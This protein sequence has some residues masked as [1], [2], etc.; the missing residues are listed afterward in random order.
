M[1][2]E[3]QRVATE[4]LCKL[5][6]CG[7]YRKNEEAFDEAVDSASARA[8]K[9]WELCGKVRAAVQVENKKE[10]EVQQDH[11]GGMEVERM[12]VAP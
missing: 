7:F 9:G 12:S 6:L 8:A 1:N 10:D 4:S 11:F 2:E 5:M 3:V